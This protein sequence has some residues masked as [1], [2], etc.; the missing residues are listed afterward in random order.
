MNNG[1]CY[2]CLHELS[3]YSREARCPSCDKAVHVCK[4]CRFY[5]P[6]LS[7]D[8]S[9]PIAEHITDKTRPN[10][11]DYFSPQTHA[12]NN[13]QTTTEDA[14]KAAEDLFNF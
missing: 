1:N 3:D 11:C 2:N 8:C 5:K 14:L 7:N 12:S 4:N 10:F 9:E 6:G 13:S